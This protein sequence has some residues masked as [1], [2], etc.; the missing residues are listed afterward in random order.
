MLLEWDFVKNS[1]NC[2]DIQFSTQ[3]ELK[4]LEQIQHLNL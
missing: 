3:L 1:L 2:G 4:I